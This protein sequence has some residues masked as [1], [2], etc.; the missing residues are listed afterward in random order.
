MGRGHL[1]FQRI[2]SSHEMFKLCVDEEN[3]S[4]DSCLYLMAGA[5]VQ[6]RRRS[7]VGTGLA[8]SGVYL[9]NLLR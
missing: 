5:V 4:V 8:F 7:W 6:G 1:R 2:W 3:M 9:S